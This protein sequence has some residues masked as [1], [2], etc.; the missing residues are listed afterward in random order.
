MRMKG[1]HFHDL[2]PASPTQSPS[3]M[4]GGHDDSQG[5]VL[6]AIIQSEAVSISPV[7]LRPAATSVDTTSAHP[8]KRQR[9]EGTIVT[10]VSFDSKAPVPLLFMCL[11]LF[12]YLLIDDTSRT[13]VLIA[14]TSS[15]SR[16]ACNAPA[17]L[18]TAF[19]V[20]GA[21][22]VCRPVQI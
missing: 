21:W 1:I 10:S 12:C 2:E 9:V 11:C 18:E 16:K 13:P 6:P 15:R 19:H 3:A 5:S 8:N 14:A 20:D 17:T 4:N 22:D 7:V